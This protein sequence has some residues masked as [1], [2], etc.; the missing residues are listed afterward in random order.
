M[1]RVM[2]TTKNRIP[3]IITAAIIVIAVLFAYLWISGTFPKRMT[4]TEKLSENFTPKFKNTNFSLNKLPI[5][6]QDEIRH[7]SSGNFTLDK[8]EFDPVNGDEINL[9]AH[10]V[11]NEEAVEDFQRKKIGNYTIHIIHDTEF[12]TARREVEAYLSQLRKNPAYQIA[13]FDWITDSFADPPRQ[14]VEL[15]CYSSTP[16]NRNLDN[17]IILGW[18]ILVYPVLPIPTNTVLFNST[19][20]LNSIQNET[21][22]NSTAS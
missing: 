19:A 7:Y 16:E 18:K 22:A 6:F 3:L 13:N 11:R 12:E 14:Y 5:E 4:T 8:W 2:M 10:S 20:S 17:K 9:Y 15:W 1:S 21:A